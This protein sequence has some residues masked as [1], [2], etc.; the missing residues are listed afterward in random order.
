MGG[1]Q[2]N[3]QKSL[4]SCLKLLIEDIELY[5]D[6]KI[7]NQLKEIFI[8]FPSHFE[9]NRKKVIKILSKSIPPQIL[10]FE[11]ILLN[12]ISSV[13]QCSLIANKLNKQ[14]QIQKI[15]P[16]FVRNFRLMN[17]EKFKPNYEGEYENSLLLLFQG[18]K[19]YCNLANQILKE[20]RNN[21][22][23]Q[24]QIYVL[25]WEHYQ[26]HLIKFSKDPDYDLSPINKSFDEKF[27][28]L[29][30]ELKIEI[31]GAKLW[32]S[33]VVQLDVDFILDEFKLAR[34]SNNQSQ[35]PF[36][37]L[38]NAMI[39]INIDVANLQ[40]IGRSD[41]QFSEQLKD[42]I[43]FIQLDSKEFMNNLYFESKGDLLVFFEKW[44]KDN[45]FL[46]SALPLW[47]CENYLDGLFFEY[48][49]EKIQENFKLLS[50]VEQKK[51]IEQYSNSE[52]I[53]QPIRFEDSFQLQ[54]N[55]KYFQFDDFLQKNSE[56]IL[57]KMIKWLKSEKQFSNIML[58]SESTQQGGSA[59]INYQDIS[60]CVFEENHQ[61]EQG[62]Q[63]V[64]VQSLIQSQIPE[65]N[66]LNEQE[67][68]IVRICK[69][70]DSIKNVIQSSIEQRDENIIFRNRGLNPIPIELID[71]FSFIKP[72]NEIQAIEIIKYLGKQKIK[73][74]ALISS[75]LSN[76]IEFAKGSMAA[77]LFSFIK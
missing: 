53:P 3:R 64:K 30:P 31:I 40:W 66:I 60:N 22:L 52:I 1:A 62:N 50:Q 63:E 11:D 14:I 44:E 21:K 37:Q 68:E 65:S 4:L 75:A 35:I 29:S 12:N 24:S 8:K 58:I 45:I 59:A 46:K 32:G 2:S 55:S 27:Y 41:F 17:F 70:Y 33:M 74:K 43:Q 54:L 9:K 47:I 56:Q 39:D 10:Q 73:E 77:E 36:N 49:E 23:V 15:D 72:I 7:L 42:I 76:N 26:N 57:I 25:I 34:R 38:F 13:F 20:L 28:K 16:D 71:F 67:D 5:A 48:S 19:S 51:L 69:K 18:L 6:A 61:V